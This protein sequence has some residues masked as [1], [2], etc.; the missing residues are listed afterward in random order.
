MA[1]DLSTAVMGTNPSLWP[2]VQNDVL[3]FLTTKPQDY[4]AG[5]DDKGDVCYVEYFLSPNKDT[6]LRT[7][8][9][10]AWTYANV[11]QAGQFRSA[12]AVDDGDVLATNLLARMA[13]SVRGMGLESEASEKPFV[14]LTS[15]NLLPYTG[16]T[17][18]PTNPPVAV[19]VNVAVADPEAIANK[20]L[21]K[22]Q[23]YRLRNA[24]LYSFRINLPAPA[25]P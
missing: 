13:D 23:N 1:Q 18:T 21:L 16:G 10:S 9:G 7:Y 15:T 6:L 5:A 3:Q 2:R 12:P 17:Y 25:S 24:G 20:D 19:E 8:Y 22:N 4:Q 11:L 14:I